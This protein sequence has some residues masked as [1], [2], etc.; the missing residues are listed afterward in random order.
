ML[1][2]TSLGD[3]ERK[4]IPDDDEFLC[5]ECIYD[6]VD[7]EKQ[8][9]YCSIG[10]FPSGCTKF[11]QKMPMKYKFP[12][13]NCVFSI[14]HGDCNSDHKRYSC[15]VEG[16]LTSEGCDK[17][18][19]KSS[20][21]SKPQYYLKPAEHVAWGRIAELAEAILHQC[22]M[23]VGEANPDLCE[24]WIDEIK[25]QC[26]IIESQRDYGEDGQLKKETKP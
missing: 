15:S 23:P 22:K 9:R 4:M 7:Y 11:K 8:R 24:M 16:N 2:I 12:C 5:P 13:P 25:G 10:C 21:K 20:K 26:W 14:A 6:V 17:F 1:E 19:P 3:N 18:S